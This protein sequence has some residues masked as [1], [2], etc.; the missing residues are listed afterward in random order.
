MRF[1]A[2]SSDQIKRSRVVS[3][4]LATASTIFFPFATSASKA[5]SLTVWPGNLG[6]TLSRVSSRKKIPIKSVTPNTT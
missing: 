3:A 4:I 1:V 5:R 2:G 6:V